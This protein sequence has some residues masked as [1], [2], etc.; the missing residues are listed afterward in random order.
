[1]TDGITN[2]SFSYDD[3]FIA[4]TGK[5]NTFTIWNT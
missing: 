3:K 2:L 4:A 1:M 5:N